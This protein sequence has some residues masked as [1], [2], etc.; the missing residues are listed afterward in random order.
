MT[1]SH[2]VRENKNKCLSLGIFFCSNRLIIYIFFII[3]IL[4]FYFFFFILFIQLFGS[5]IEEYLTLEEKHNNLLSE[6]LTNQSS[7]VEHFHVS[8]FKPPCL[9]GFHFG[10]GQ[11]FTNL[12]NHLLSTDTKSCRWKQE[13]RR[14][15]GGKYGDD[16][17]HHHRLGGGEGDVFGVF[18]VI[19]FPFL[20]LFFI[21]WPMLIKEPKR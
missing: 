18:S 21:H 2:R 20:F 5:E 15:G 16:D 17:D 14:R 13:R 4:S 3:S 7:Y 19:V 10:I 1:D 8:F 9:P 6:I 11:L 12:I